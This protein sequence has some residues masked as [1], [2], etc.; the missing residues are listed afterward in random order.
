MK[1]EEDN[2]N[3][4]K[5]R[6]IKK[7]TLNQMVYESLKELI[8]S[9][10]FKP[11]SKLSEVAVAEKLG[12]S[13]TPVREAFRMLASEGLV[14]IIPWKGVY[15]KEFSNDEVKEAY[16]CREAL[17]VLAISLAIDRIDEEDIKL[18]D[19]Y[20]HISS[21]IDTVTQIVDINT[22]IHEF[23]I[24]KSNNRKLALLLNSL[25]DILLHD[26]NISA[27]DIERKKE[28]EKEHLILL[29][30]IKNRD[31]VKAQDAMR[32]HIRNGYNYIQK[33]S[34]KINIIE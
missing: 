30:A 32:H 21:N 7:K 18:L 13:A 15:I 28:I 29:N 26:R 4:E 2:I 34:N 22:K 12:V 33:R 14:E 16:Q 11:K 17:E 20:I 27:Y 23:I 3:I 24:E 6:K 9:G 19:E 8:L 5:S 10:G 31:K 1:K 25:D